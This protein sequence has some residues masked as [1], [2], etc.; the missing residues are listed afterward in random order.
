MATPKPRPVPVEIGLECRPTARDSYMRILP[1]FLEHGGDF[2]KDIAG[3]LGMSVEDLK[4]EAA[5]PEVV[6]LIFLTAAMVGS[7][8]VDG[9]KWRH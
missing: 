2:A 4:T 5:K 3:Q 9:G 6:P 1:I 8:C 7:R